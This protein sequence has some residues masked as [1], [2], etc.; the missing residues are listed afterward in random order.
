VASARAWALAGPFGAQLGHHVVELRCAGG[1]DQTIDRF[2][3]VVLDYV[4]KP[5]CQS[6]G[7]AECPQRRRWFRR[8]GGDLSRLVGVDRLFVLPSGN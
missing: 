6:C 4:D 8:Y 3:A 2:R 5:G 7:L 1:P